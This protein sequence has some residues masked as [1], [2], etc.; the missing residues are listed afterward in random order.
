MV[1]L[2]NKDYDMAVTKGNGVKVKSGRVHVISREKGWAVK[3]EGTARA[4]RVFISKNAAINEARKSK[5][6]GFD[7]IIHKSNGTVAKWEKAY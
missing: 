6:N 2:I 1:T 4:Q 5:K 3:R 7:V